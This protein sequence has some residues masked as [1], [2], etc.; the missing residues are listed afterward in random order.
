MTIRDWEEALALQIKIKKLERGS[1]GAR[2]EEDKGM[3]WECLG[4]RDWKH[5]GS[6]QRTG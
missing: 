3:G 2:K 6:G 1:L 4:E 5:T